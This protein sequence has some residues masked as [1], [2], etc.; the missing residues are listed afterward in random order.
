M[1]RRSVR[2]RLVLFG[3]V[4]LLLYPFE[5]QVVP[6]WRLCV[7]D[8]AGQPMVDIGARLFWFHYSLQWSYEG[9]GEEIKQTDETGCVSFGEKKMRASLAQWLIVSG[10][11]LLSFPHS[12]W[13]PSGHIVL[14]LGP[15]NYATEPTWIKYDGSGPPPERVVVKWRRPKAESTSNELP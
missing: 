6:A 12:G 2:R 3:L 9:Q 13:G 8:E 10:L 4:L 14:L 5:W 7:V 11:Q 1:A 15:A